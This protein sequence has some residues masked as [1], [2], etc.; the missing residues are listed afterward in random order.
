MDGARKQSMCGKQQKREETDLTQVSD[1]PSVY[2]RI[3]CGASRLLE[4]VGRR[5]YVR[6]LVFDLSDLYLEMMVGAG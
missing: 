2:T 3:G 1:F 6:C 4:V 5:D